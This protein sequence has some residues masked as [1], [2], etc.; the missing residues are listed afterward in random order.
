[1]LHKVHRYN[2]TLGMDKIITDKHCKKI[3]KYEKGYYSAQH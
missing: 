2:Y 1:M 3:E